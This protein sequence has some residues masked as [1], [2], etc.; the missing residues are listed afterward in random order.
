MPNRLILLNKNP[1]VQVTEME[2][3]T[4][5]HF[6]YTQGSLKQAQAP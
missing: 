1:W 3:H 6:H 5:Y 2:K 4:F